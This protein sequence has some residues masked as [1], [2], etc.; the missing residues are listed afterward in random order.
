MRF[1]RNT[2]VATLGAGQTATLAAG[3]L[4][5][6]VD[7]DDDNGYRPAGLFGV[8]SNPISTSSLYAVDSGYGSTFGAGNA[9]HRVR[10]TG[11]RVA[12]WYFP[13]AVTS[14]PGV[15]M[16]TTTGRERLRMCGCNRR[17]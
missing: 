9:T 4:G 8:S 2:T 15:S 12:R 13:P 10:C 16:P 14:G 11:I 17:R 5:A 1:W 3:T 7:V 6:E